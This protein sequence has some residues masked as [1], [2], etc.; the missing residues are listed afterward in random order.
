MLLSIF[1][2][3]LLLCGAVA[4]A[5]EQPK[6][7]LE[8]IWEI[9]ESCN[10]HKD[11]I[12][13][14][15]HDAVIMVRSALSD[16]AQLA[17]APPL[18]KNRS[19]GDYARAKRLIYFL[20]GIKIGDEEHENR[21]YL[22]L[23]DSMIT[24]PLRA[25]HSIGKADTKRMAGVFREMNT[26]FTEGVPRP[27]EGY[28]GKVDKPLLLC[29]QGMWEWL[30]LDDAD[31]L[32]PAGRKLS[33][34]RAQVI[35]DLNS[36]LDADV[37]GAWS[38]TKKKL[39]MLTREKGDDAGICPPGVTGKVSIE[40]DWLTICDPV[41]ESESWTTSKSAVERGSEIVANDGVAL[42]DFGRTL[43]QLLIHEFAHYYSGRR[44]RSCT[45]QTC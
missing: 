4:Q 23:V 1:L 18:T 44:A 45:F 9:D 40:F 14:A 27:D 34:S 36:R 42:S 2:Q 21:E 22:E 30:D 7:N 31:P 37:V 13:K 6:D 41:F 32:D 3:A 12:K 15:Y 25:P 24:L 33:E 11:E 26:A 16:L 29:G 10:D 39:V 8:K 5:V 43:S 17:K 28:S 35:E 38:Y 19:F 20:F